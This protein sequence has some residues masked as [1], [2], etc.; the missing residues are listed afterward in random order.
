MGAASDS[1]GSSAATALGAHPLLV[2]MPEHLEDMVYEIYGSRDIAVKPCPFTQA[3]IG[4][5]EMTNEMLIYVPQE[6]SE[7]QMIEL[8]K[9][10]TNF[11]W[12]VEQNMIRSPMTDESNW[13]ICSA[14]P[15]PEMLGQSGQNIS[16]VYDEEGLD[17]MDF[18]RYLAFL[19]AYR[20][21]TD[22]YPDFRQWC[23]LIGGHYDRSG[24]SL[25][26]FDRYGNFGHHGWMKN[27]KAKMAG[28]RYVIF[29]PRKHITPETAKLARPRRGVRDKVGHEAGID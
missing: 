10:N 4:E 16:R 1:H 2:H 12:A 6:I 27:F 5:L 23:L 28:G 20:Y 13:L 26:G 15:I 11:N 19:L 17:G 3:E 9:F 24:I 14:S 25:V 18:R 8:G 29:A 21:L 7:A 22:E